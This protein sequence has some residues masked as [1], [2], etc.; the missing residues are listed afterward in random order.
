MYALKWEED[1]TYKQQEVV[2]LGLNVII[3]ILYMCTPLIHVHVHALFFVHNVCTCILKQVTV[4]L[5]KQRMSPSIQSVQT[6][7]SI[8]RATPLPSVTITRGEGV[9]QQNTTQQIM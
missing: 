6:N 1:T 9:A 5:D 8:D 3:Y 7:A 2:T 4:L